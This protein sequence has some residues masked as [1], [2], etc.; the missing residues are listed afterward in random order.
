MALKYFQAVINGFVNNT[1]EFMILVGYKGTLAQPLTSGQ[2][3]WYIY[4]SVN[5]LFL[6]QIGENVLDNGLTQTYSQ[7]ATGDYYKKRILI[8]PGGQ[9]TAGGGNGTVDS[10]GQFI[11]GTLEEVAPLL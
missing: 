3:D 4:L 11:Q 10:F 9:L 6:D 5:G 7:L 2:N 1:N 8:P